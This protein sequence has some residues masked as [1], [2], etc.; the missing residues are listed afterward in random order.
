MKAELTIDTK[1]L[2]REVA[3]EVIKV[4]RPMLANNPS[5]DDTILDVKGL[6]A[7]LKVTPHWIYQQTHLKTIPYF[8]LGNQLRFKKKEIDKW[9]ESLNNPAVSLPGHLRVIK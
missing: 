1:E 6:V 7:Y 4:I 2:A 3:Q 9:L 8:K 5:G